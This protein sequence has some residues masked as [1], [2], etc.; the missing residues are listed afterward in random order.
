[1]RTLPSAKQESQ[2][3]TEEIQALSNVLVTAVAA[4]QRLHARHVASARCGAENAGC[5]KTQTGHA[6]RYSLIRRCTSPWRHSLPVPSFRLSG[7]ACPGRSR[8]PS[9]RRHD[10]GRSI[11]VQ[12]PNQHIGAPYPIGD[13]PAPAPVARPPE[14]FCPAPFDT[15]RE[16][17]TSLRIT[18]F[19]L[20]HGSR[21][22]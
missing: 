15:S 7:R 8:S 19:T 12:V 17:G 4:M 6:K 3:G 5:P 11:T 21:S 14:P 16:P 18:Q 22:T 2:A 9:R 1:M 13:R 10:V 20:L